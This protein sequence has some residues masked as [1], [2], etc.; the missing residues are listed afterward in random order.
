MIL[1][2]EE[3]KNEEDEKKMKKTKRFLNTNIISQKNIC[4]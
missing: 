3:K 4:V 1:Q 2:D